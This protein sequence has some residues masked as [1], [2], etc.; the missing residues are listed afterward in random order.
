MF[1]T[2]AGAALAGL[3]SAALSHPGRAQERCPLEHAPPVVASAVKQTLA[4]NR[5]AVIVALGSSSTEGVRASSL[6]NTYPARLQNDLASALPDAHIAVIN[7]GIGGQDAL[8][9]SAR[10]EKD[11][12][13][14]QPAMVIWQVG[15]NG[16]IGHSDPDVFRTLVSNGIERLQ[17]FGID[18]VLMD[19]QRAPMIL[20]APQ[21]GRFDQILAELAVKYKIS[22]FSRGA[23]MDEWK[24]DGLAYDHFLSGDNVHMND[25]GYRCTADALAA[26]IEEGLGVTAAAQI[27]APRPP[28]TGA[29]TL[30]ASK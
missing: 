12:I 6:S 10:L 26:S 16:A 15:A 28:P 14:M 11:V 3:L 29:S 17:K 7:R 24:A 2:I 1:Q 5:E 8:E 30:H 9:E 25:V 13:A 19:N 18:V 27:A 23:L 21:H 20:A 4:A 22:L